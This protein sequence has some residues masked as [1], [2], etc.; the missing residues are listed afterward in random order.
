[1]D[2]DGVSPSLG[3]KNFGGTKYKIVNLD[4]REEFRMVLSEAVKD[5]P[6][7]EAGSEGQAWGA[8]LGSHCCSLVYKQ[9]K[10]IRPYHSVSCPWPPL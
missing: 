7:R 5:M 3:T 2:R 10:S 8:V 1:M 6:G 9:G 4:P